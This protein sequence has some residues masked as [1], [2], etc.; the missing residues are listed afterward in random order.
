MMNPGH[1]SCIGNASSFNKN[2]G[3]KKSLQLLVRKKTQVSFVLLVSLVYV[4]GSMR[5][6]EKQQ[7]KSQLQSRFCDCLIFSWIISIIRKENLECFLICKAMES[8][9]GSAFARTITE[10]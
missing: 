9:E 7:E 5:T 1:Q 4:F 6:S 10:G 2:Q 8:Y 3:W